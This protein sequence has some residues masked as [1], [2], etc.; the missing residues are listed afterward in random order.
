MLQQVLLFFMFLSPP[1]CW[2]VVRVAPFAVGSAIELEGAETV[3][4]ETA[5]A[6]SVAYAAQVKPSP[7]CSVLL[8]DLG[9]FWASDSSWTP[10]GIDTFDD[11]ELLVVVHDA[12]P[13]SCIQEVRPQDDCDCL[14]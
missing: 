7:F 6:A 8:I 1:G 14:L 12:M 13:P 10:R 3:E 9:T 4:C 2:L 5:A 11:F